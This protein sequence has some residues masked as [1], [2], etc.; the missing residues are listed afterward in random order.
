M[1]ANMPFLLRVACFIFIFFNSLPAMAHGT[2]L[3]SPVPFKARLEVVRVDRAGKIIVAG[4]AKK[5]Q[6]VFVSWGGQKI[7][8]LKPE[9]K[10]FVYGMGL[11]KDGRVVIAGHEKQG[12]RSR[13]YLAVFR[14]DKEL[15]PHF[16]QNGKVILN[17][18]G[19]AELHYLDLDS[20]D[21]MVVGGFLKT[22][23]GSH[24][25]LIARFLSDGSFDR[26]F[27]SAIAPFH[28]SRIYGLA[29]DQQNRIIVAGSLKD[30]H[31]FL[32]CF[33]ARFNQ[34]GRPDF[35]FGEKGILHPDFKSDSSLCSSVMVQRDGKILVAGYVQDQQAQANFIVTRFLVNGQR[36]PSFGKAGR[37]TI[38]F[39][40]RADAAHALAV[41]A[42]GFILVAGE[43]IEKNREEFLAWAVLNPNGK[44]ISKE[45]TNLGI[46]SEAELSAATW[47]TS[48]GFIAVGRMGGRAVSK[49]ISP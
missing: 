37:V 25:W 4:V 44:M 2:G 11:L 34:S 10:G 40:H 27:H 42:H 29:I 41:D 19:F 35:S 21:R 15:D 30:N 6:Q 26:S 39:D 18:K 46:R 49:Q 33:M 43:S 7:S 23:N 48:R 13:A 14:Q 16:G 47:S 32:K 8:W 22:K 9:G 24:H 3:G 31:R 5:K 36:D 38:D 20:K 1:P 45:K 12:N 17:L 28:D